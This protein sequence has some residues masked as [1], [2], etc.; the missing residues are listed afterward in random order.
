MTRSLHHLLA[1]GVFALLTVDVAGAQ[2]TPAQATPLGPARVPPA[3]T[4]PPEDY[5]IGPNDVLSIVFWKDESMSSDVVVRP[6]GRISLPLINEV[7]AAGLT[8]EELR[9]KIAELAVKYFPDPTVSVIPKQINSRV[10][11]I[12]GAVGKGGPYALMQPTNVLQLIAL[13]GGL[14][15]WAKEDRIWILRTE[16]GKPLRFR[17][18]Y[19]EML[20]GKN[21]QQNIQLKPG[22]TVLVP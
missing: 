12:M 18:N 17:F 15:E 2:A 16:N 1:A 7:D 3:P 11:Y 9:L 21:P 22:D 4:A 10:V 5:I 8:P 13:A 20:E 19:K 6:D 14:G